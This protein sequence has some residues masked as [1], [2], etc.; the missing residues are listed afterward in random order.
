MRVINE[1]ARFKDPRTIVAGAFE[2]KAR[3]FVV[4][5]G[6]SP[7]IPPIP[8]LDAVDYLTNETVFD[9]KRLPSRLI[10]IGGGPAGL[11]LAQAYRRL[12]SAVT[13]VE[14]QTAL[15]REDPELAGIVLR[16]LRAEGVDIRE[17][18][19]V[20]RV[21]RRGKSGVRVHLEAADGGGETIDGTHLLVAAGRAANVDSLDLDK[22]GIAFTPKGIEVTDALRT[23]RPA[24]PSPTRNSRM[25]A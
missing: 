8:G 18:T 14:A 12:G 7:L 20:S 3:R 4:A 10:V 25:S 2:I 19:S 9:L 24:S 16:R 6:S 15:G 23:T 11:E 1:E 5:T 21:E 13:V 17:K 22:A